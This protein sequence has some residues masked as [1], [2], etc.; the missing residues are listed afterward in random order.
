MACGKCRERGR[1]CVRKD[2]LDMRYV[3]GWDE[4]SD[5]RVE[6][7][8]TA[9]GAWRAGDGLMALT[10]AW[11]LPIRVVAVLLRHVGIEALMKL[12]RVQSDEWDRRRSARKS[13]RA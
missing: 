11:P 10:D 4:V 7:I 6:A 2:F 12:R 5:G 3:C 1:W 8:R 13:A 9:G